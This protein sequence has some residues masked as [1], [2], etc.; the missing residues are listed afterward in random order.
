MPDKCK[1][2][3]D[4]LGLGS[5]LTG[6]CRAATNPGKAV[7]D[8]AGSAF[9]KIAHSFAEAAGKFLKATTAGWLNLKHPDIDSDTGPIH[10]LQEK[11]HWLVMWIAVLSL[12]IAAGRMALTRRS[13]PAVDAARGIF[14]LVIVAPASVAIL[15]LVVAAGDIFSVWI[16]DESLKCPT[17]LNPGTVPEFACTDQYNDRIRAMAMVG[18]GTGAAL[19]LLLSG[20]LILA[21]FIQ[22]IHMFISGAMIILLGGTLPLAAAGATTESGK[23]WF[24]KSCGWLGAFALFKP[25]SAIVYAAAFQSMGTNKTGDLLTVLHGVVL[26]LMAAFTLPALLR[27]VTPMVQQV[28][29]GRGGAAAVA[30]MGKVVATGAKAVPE[31]R[32]MAM[33]SKAKKGADGGTGAHKVP[34]HGGGHHGGGHHGGGLAPGQQGPSG[35]QGGGT[36]GQQQGPQGA[37]GGHTGPQG[38]PGAQTTGTP[39]AGRGQTAGPQGTAAVPPQPQTAPPARGSAGG[40]PPSGAGGHRPTTPQGGPRVGN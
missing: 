2:I 19:L 7:S 33:A 17:H 8:L 25:V 12:L 34:S 20:F 18:E 38:T 24:R 30:F 3:T 35:P 21:S 40:P 6:A 15:N 14:L 37:P 36:P 29:T 22:I 27:F 13:T 9:D 11:T 1:V 32:A 16:V 4:P 31:V 28:A 10:F 26:L 23:A 5:P 39:G